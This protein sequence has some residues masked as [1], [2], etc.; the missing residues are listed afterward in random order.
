MKH[1]K[2]FLNFYV[3]TF[4]FL[5]LSGCKTKEEPQPQPVV[6]K[7]PVVTTADVTVFTQVTATCGGNVTSDGGGAVTERGVCWST[8]P[9]PTVTGSHQAIGTGTGVFSQVIAGLDLG[10]KYYIKAYATNSSGTG[11][12]EEKSFTTDATLALGIPY[13]G[14]IIF[15]LDSTG[16]HGIVC[17]L[18]DMSFKTKW[19]CP[20][21]K[22]SGALPKEV[23]KGASNTLA[24]LAA[25]SDVSNAADLCAKYV[26]GGY[27]DWFLP[28]EEE[29]YLMYLNLHTKNLGNFIVTYYWCSTQ[30]PVD[31]DLAMMVMFIDGGRGNGGKNNIMPVR[32]ARAF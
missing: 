31:D 10:T 21:K 3:I 24:I 7:T 27:S 32:A 8:S 6:V 13:A 17:A 30:S 16:K 26:S 18:A 9:N 23:G 19:G 1:S 20:T 28:S 5:C 2:I 14:G 4:A 12:G 29:V 25:C 22:I 11:Y 15:Y